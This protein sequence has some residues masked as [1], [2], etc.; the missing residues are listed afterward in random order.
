M[1]RDESFTW[2]IYRESMRESS[3]IHNG[4]DL[5]GIFQGRNTF[6]CSLAQFRIIGEAVKNVSEETRQKYPK[7]KW[8]KVAGFSR[9][10]Y[11]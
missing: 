8:R 9:H 3:A 4:D 6:R 7:V 11:T 5:Q 10:R 2:R 1:S